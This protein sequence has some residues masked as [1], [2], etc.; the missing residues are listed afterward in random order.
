MQND[1]ND[2]LKACRLALGL[3]LRPSVIRPH[4]LHS[5]NKSLSPSHQETVACE[6]MVSQ[7]YIKMAFIEYLWL[8]V[9][10]CVTQ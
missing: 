3:T 4:L 5:S 10:A 7:A 2:I 8:S 9:S 1:M 6:M